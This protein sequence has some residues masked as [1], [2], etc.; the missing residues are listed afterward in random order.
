M[1]IFSLED[2]LD[3]TSINQA[4]KTSLEKN[5]PRVHWIWSRVR[6]FVYVYV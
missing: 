1:K 2:F 3:D 4:R 5:L 6:V